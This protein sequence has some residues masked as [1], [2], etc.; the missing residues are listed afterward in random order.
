MVLFIVFTILVKTVNVA[1]VGPLGSEVGFSTLNINMYLMYDYNELWYNLTKGIGI[2]AIVV[3][4]FFALLGISELIS[5]KSFKKVTPSLYVLGG[6]YVVM[7]LFYV[8]FEKVVINYRPMILD[9]LE[10]LEASYPSSHTMLVIV[11]MLTCALQAKERLQNAK[12]IWLIEIL[13][14]VC[15]ALMIVGRMLSGV[16]WFTDIVGGVILGFS[17]VFYYMGFAGLCRRKVSV[18][19]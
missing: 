11:V 16:H 8:L 6:T 2:L 13:C 3:V 15:T 5:R 10:G 7:A 9:P 17:L 18:N 1:A 14:A 12:L 4:A 19:D